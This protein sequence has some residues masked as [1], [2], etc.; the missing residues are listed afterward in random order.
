MFEIEALVLASTNRPY[1]K[2]DGSQTV[3]KSVTVRLELNGEKELVTFPTKIDLVGHL[4]EEV[5]LLFSPRV[6]KGECTGLEVQG[7]K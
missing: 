2:K 7:V 5:V 4:D 3:Y 1:T 6:Y